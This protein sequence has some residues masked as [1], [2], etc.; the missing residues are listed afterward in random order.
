MKPFSLIAVIIGTSLF[1]T[2]CGQK[3]KAPETPSS[4]EASAVAVEAISPQQQ[5][6]I[7]S[8]DQPILDEKNK[9]VPADIANAPA[10]A[11]TPHQDHN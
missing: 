5:S 1:L 3:D 8:V 4:S 11:V 7:D 9:D 10:D 2:A 6:A